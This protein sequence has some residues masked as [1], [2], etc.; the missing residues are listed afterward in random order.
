MTCCGCTRS[1]WTAFLSGCSSPAPPCHRRRRPCSCGNHG[2][3]SS[4]EH[5]SLGIEFPRACF[6][7]FHQSNAPVSS[8]CSGGAQAVAARRCDSFPGR[9]ASAWRPAHRRGPPH[10][11]HAG[12]AA[13]AARVDARALPRRVP[14]HVQII[15]TR[16]AGKVLMGQPE[17]NLSRWCHR[18]TC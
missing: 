15:A 11:A 6:L 10:P 7:L 14:L 12:P 5:Q 4:R 16:Y 9:G 18:R 2:R 8:V 13:G 3:P 17:E 1:K